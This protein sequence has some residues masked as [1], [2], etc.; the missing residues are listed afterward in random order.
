MV[1]RG[2]NRI[3]RRGVLNLVELGMLSMV[4]FRFVLV[5]KTIENGWEVEEC[6]CY[7]E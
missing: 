4:S 7:C 3:G 5:I 6:Y 2:L 1:V